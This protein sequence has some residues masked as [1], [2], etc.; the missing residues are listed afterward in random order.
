MGR[1]VR[2]VGNHKGNG[3]ALKTIQTESGRE[4]IRKY[5]FE[6]LTEYPDGRI[7]FSLEARDLFPEIFQSVRVKS[8]ER[9]LA[10]EA[11][12]LVRESEKY[13]NSL[14]SE[15][16][17]FLPPDLLESHEK[18][19]LSIVRLG[20]YE[21]LEKNSNPEQIYREFSHLY[22][23]YIDRTSPG[24]ERGKALVERTEKLLFAAL[25]AQ[26]QYCV[27]NGLTLTRDLTSLSPQIIRRLSKILGYDE[28]FPP[29]SFAIKLIEGILTHKDMLDAILQKFFKRKRW[30]TLLPAYRDI[31]RI[32]L[33]ELLIG[34]ASP[35]A[36]I[37]SI[38]IL[39]QVITAQNE[40][41]SAKEKE[42]T[43][44]FLKTQLIKCA[45]SLGRAL[46][47]QII[48]SLAFTDIRSLAQL[49]EAYAVSPFNISG[50]ALTLGEDVYSWKLVKGVWENATK[51]DEVIDKFSHKWRAE[52]MGKIEV[53]L[54]RMALYEMIYEHVAAR[55]VI[56]ETMDI[57]D[58]FGA[59]EAKNL[60]NG[61]LDAVS[62]SDEF[63]F[64]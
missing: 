20:L 4:Q 22:Q 19:P 38:S 32:G 29:P 24:S 59:E 35:Q 43:E 40:A 7:P 64:I 39:L 14:N 12:D 61:I 9:K 25:F 15:L 26:I 49:K 47:F 55:I 2:H 5:A 41:L 46:A 45:R 31:L 58:M 33:F 13:K 17:S 57:A 36:I 6:A 53:T 34:L 27:W 48:Y 51:L 62:K 30:I 37:L 44:T 11:L 54:L 23:N 18:L 3:A 63:K 16:A 42:Q 8:S 10:E 56:S 52:R 1:G 28:E 50:Q 21:V 60:V